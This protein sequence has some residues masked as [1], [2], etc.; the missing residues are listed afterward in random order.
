MSEKKLPSDWNIDHRHDWNIYYCHLRVRCWAPFQSK[1]KFRY[2]LISFSAH[3]K[4]FSS[5]SN[6]LYRYNLPRFWKRL[7]PFPSIDSIITL[8][9][10]IASQLWESSPWR[11]HPQHPLLLPQNIS[12]WRS[13]DVEL[14]IRSVG[15]LNDFKVTTTSCVNWVTFS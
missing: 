9:F 7:S 12:H 5:P 1:L 11:E 10:D 6:S 15:K 4:F 3:S 14:G 8:L 2:I 13:A